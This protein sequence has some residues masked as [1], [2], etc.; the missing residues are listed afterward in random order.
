MSAMENDF[1][2]D[3]GREVPRPNAPG[4]VRTQRQRYDAL[5]RLSDWALCVA[6]LAPNLGAAK[7]VELHKIVGQHAKSGDP[8]TIDPNSSERPILPPV[9][10][11]A[12]DWFRH[13]IAVATPHPLPDIFARVSDLSG[14]RLFTPDAQ[15]LTYQGTDLEMLQRACADAVI[16]FGRSKTRNE[17]ERSNPLPALRWNV[18]CAIDDLAVGG[19]DGVRA[20]R[21]MR[22]LASLRH[23]TKIIEEISK[24]R[25]VNRLRRE[26]VQGWVQGALN[27]AYPDRRDAS[28]NRD[29][30]SAE[31]A[32]LVRV[33]GLHLASDLSGVDEERLNDAVVKSQIK[34]NVGDLVQAT[35]EKY[36]VQDASQLSNSEMLQV[37]RDLLVTRSLELVA[38]KDSTARDLAPLLKLLMERDAQERE[39]VIEQRERDV[40]QTIGFLQTL[41][42]HLDHWLQGI[43][44]QIELDTGRQL[45]IRADPVTM[46][47]QWMGD[48]PGLMHMLGVNG[49]RATKVIDVQ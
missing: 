8:I 12:A 37:Q 20:D 15:D 39:Q 1:Q 32:V 29:M 21:Q 38:S 49:S 33:F 43:I 27:E 48:D 28:F 18:D 25:I 16:C 44:R 35:L 30:P 3:D 22:A 2:A 14:G 10:G 7:A 31:L 17:I 40:E 6:L 19:G 4:L 13:A 24:L 34:F 5:E 9:K 45:G 11:A 23:S 26:D 47:R 46:L 41:A 36:G 42:G